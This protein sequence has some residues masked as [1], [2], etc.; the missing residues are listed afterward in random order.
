MKDDEEMPGAAGKDEEIPGVAGKEKETAG[1]EEEKMSNREEEKNPAGSQAETLLGYLLVTAA[2]GCGYLLCH[3]DDLSFSANQ[4]LTDKMVG[5]Q[6]ELAE[7][8]AWAE[9]KSGSSPWKSF[10]APALSSMRK[11]PPRVNL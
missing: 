9:E 6:Q 4:E 8:E 11:R 3:H 10:G 2:S 7:T 5:I 1:M